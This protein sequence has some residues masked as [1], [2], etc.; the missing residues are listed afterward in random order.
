MIPLSSVDLFPR[1]V[2]VFGREC[3]PVREF[4]YHT[5]YVEFD[6]FDQASIFKIRIT[7]DVD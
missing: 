2:H 3:G 5:S 4:I 7:K 1:P 6:L